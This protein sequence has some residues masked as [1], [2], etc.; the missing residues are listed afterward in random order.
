MKIQ[1]EG[2]MSEVLEAIAMLGASMVDS[3][4]E[5]PSETEVDASVNKCVAEA[6]KEMGKQE[7]GNVLLKGLKEAHHYSHTKGAYIP[8]KDMN[9]LH[10]MNVMRQKLNGET[11]SETF[12]DTEFRALVLALAEKIKTDTLENILGLEVFG[13]HGRG[14]FYTLGSL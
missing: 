2:E 10:I 9:E 1:F 5:V 6:Q 8:V 4:E 3:N 12:T 11:T 7:S 14:M 13:K